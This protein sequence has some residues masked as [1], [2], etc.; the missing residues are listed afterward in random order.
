MAPPFGFRRI[1]NQGRP[2]ELTPI[3]LNNLP[4]RNNNSEQKRRN[5][6]DE[7]HHNTPERPDEET[8]AD[9]I[10][11][12]TTP[13]LAPTPENEPFQESSGTRRSHSYGANDGNANIEGRS[14]ANANNS[15]TRRII[16][17]SFVGYL[18]SCT[19]WVLIVTM[20]VLGY[21]MFQHLR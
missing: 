15:N 21:W 7:N 2:Y 14:R 6:P 11:N 12:Q 4:P 17:P 8:C 13:T 1:K 19:M 9:R 3:A 20:F 16:Y 5:Q 10:D 18:Q